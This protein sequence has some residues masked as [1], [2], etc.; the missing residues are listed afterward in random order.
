MTLHN[1]VRLSLAAG[2]L[3]LC[4]ACAHLK[5]SDPEALAAQW[6]EHL[7]ARDYSGA[8]DVY[9][10]AVRRIPDDK[11]LQRSYLRAAETLKDL[12]DREHGRG[13]FGQ[14]ERIYAALLGAYRGLEK[15]SARPSFTRA[16]LQDKRT[17]VRIGET[18]EAVKRHISLGDYRKALDVLRNTSRNLRQEPRFLK[19]YAGAVEAVKQRADLAYAKEDFIGAGQIYRLL[20]TDFALFD[21]FARTL[22]FP[23]VSLNSRISEC[24]SA[25]TRRGLELYRQGKISEA[26]GVWEGIIVFYDNPDTRK[27][28]GTAAEQL[29]KLQR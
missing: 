20:L 16:D 2:F 14:A 9:A 24:S 22:S 6:K 5:K 12:G 11:A 3:L 19:V 13:G 21:S 18:E 15:L 29:N 1:C 27:M 26:I 7:D 4:L 8:L 23:R 17:L 10:S 25:L 28:I